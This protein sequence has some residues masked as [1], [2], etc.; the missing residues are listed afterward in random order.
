MF[1]IITPTHDPRWLD[2][3]LQSLEA[4]TCGDWE[5]IVVP[6]NGCQIPN[7]VAEHSKVRV[8]PFSIPTNRIGALKRFCCE[9]VKGEIIVELDHDDLL[10]PNCMTALAEAFE[11]EVDFVYSNHAEFYDETRQPYTYDP[12]YG[13]IFR[14]REFYGHK[15]KEIV[16]FEPT[17]HS[18]S[19]IHHAPNHVR[20][21]R[22]SAYWDIGGHDPDME[23]ADDHDLVCRF[24]LHKRMKHID[25]CLY[26]YRLHGDNSY[27]LRNAKVQEGTANVRRRYLH[28]MIERWVELEGLSKVDLGAAHNKPDGYIGVDR[29]TGSAVDVVHD[30]SRGLPFEDGSIGLVRAFDFLEHIPGSVALMNE[31]YRVLVDGGWLIT[32]T[33]S[34]DGR[35]AFQDPSHIS[36]W[37]E[38]SFW[39]YTDES[40]A[41]YVPDLYARFQVGRLETYFPTEFHRQRDIPYVYADL[42]AVKSWR[43]RPG[44]IKC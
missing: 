27:L 19:L 28:A 7:T 34:T 4:Q 42:V 25:N 18:C 8:V 38:N 14:D 3:A 43:R 20:A 13:W 21:W 40:Y 16:D 30:V 32:C 24:Y 37:N 26:L 12:S 31:I 33:P 5:W 23:V 35:G 39:Y 41:K 11:D 9:Q 15:F 22:T 17:A 10:T 36:F 1:S 6:N 29:Y 2:Q 44:L